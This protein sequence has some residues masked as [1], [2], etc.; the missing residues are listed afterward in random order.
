MDAT[1]RD[2]LQLCLDLKTRRYCQYLE[3]GIKLE[4]LDE[5]D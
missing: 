2:V 3:L 1:L 4:T 5:S